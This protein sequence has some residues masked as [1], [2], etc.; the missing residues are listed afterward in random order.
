M[1]PTMGRAATRRPPHP[2]LPLTCALIGLAL[3]ASLAPRPAHAD[4]GDPGVGGCLATTVTG[5]DVTH[6][7]GVQFIRLE[8]GLAQVFTAPD[9]LVRAVTVWLPDT[10]LV[11]T[12]PMHL[13]LY[14]T[15]AGGRPLP[16]SPVAD[17]G[18]LDTGD[19][20]AVG[21]VRVTFRF[22]PPAMLP[23]PGRYA[24]ALV[25]DRCG[26]IPVLTDGSDDFSEGDLWELGQRRCGGP[27][28]SVNSRVD[29]AH[30]VFRVE[31]C[32]GGTSTTGKTWG[33]LKARYR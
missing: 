23:A 30:L 6:N 2:A 19:L 15:D 14:G 7:D 10:R 3:T 29:V 26:V 4:A 27:L 12:I 13:F 25:P 24:V 21:A 17:G 1:T 11:L 8:R 28:T 16:D 33:E 31:F 18:S 20:D 9:T 22:D 5:L 32:D